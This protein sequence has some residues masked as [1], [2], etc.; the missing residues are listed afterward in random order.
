MSSPLLSPGSSDLI[1]V[2]AHQGNTQASSSPWFSNGPRIASASRR[3]GR[4]SNNGGPESTRGRIG[5]NSFRSSSV[6]STSLRKPPQCPTTT[7]NDLLRIGSSEDENSMSWSDTLGAARD[8]S[9]HFDLTPAKMTKLFA[10]CN[11]DENGKLPYEGFRSGLEA[12]GI[13]CDND[14]QFQA[15]LDVVDDNKSAGISYEAFVDA[16]QEMKLAQLFDDAFVRTM[17]RASLESHS[18]AAFLGTI[19]YSPDRIR[20]VYP[21]EHVK[22]FIYSTKPNWTTVRWINIEGLNTLLMRQLSVR[23]RLHPFAVED[24]LGLEVKRP[25][26]VKYD[27]HSSLILHTLHPRDSEMVTAYQDM[28]RASQFVLPQDDSP[29]DVMDQ[30]ELESRL[31]ELELGRVM[32][33]P[34]QLSL[35]VM[36]GVL[37]SV[38]ASGTNTLWS[39]LKQRLSVS[40]SKARQHSSAFLVYAVMDVCVN[41]LS[42][43]SQTFAAK[44]IMLERLMSMQPRQFDLTRIASCSKQVKAL[45]MHCQPLFEVV[46]KIIASD[47]YKGETLQDFADVQGQLSTIGDECEQHLDRCR[48]L[49][50]EFNNARAAQQNDASYILALIAAIFFPAQFLTGVYGMNFS[51]IPET[52]FYYGYF[53]WW[54]IVLINAAFIVLLFKFKQWL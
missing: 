47:D 37:I 52:T 35:Y 18:D 43:I 44:L 31:R 24:T 4:N 46:S 14:Q 20:S 5:A 16:I 3:A 6:E 32:T 23:Y 36:K 45:R 33:L 40:Y 9:V 54:A 48:S 1:S 11:P 42:P 2:L 13:T 19:E 10:L 17:P 34:D 50:Q 8:Y 41:E 22:R 15:F 38:Q 53:I 7:S 25:K 30:S 49:L 12:M 39:A 29:F 21:I 26:Y 51:Y 27:E 28:Y